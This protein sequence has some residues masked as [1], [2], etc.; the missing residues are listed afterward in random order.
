MPID[1]H[2]PQ[3]RDSYASRE[4]DASWIQQM[5]RLVDWNGKRVADIGC[6]G[7]IYS[8]ALLQLGV[9]HVYGIDFSEA[10]IQTAKELHAEESLSFLV[11]DAENTGLSNESVDIVFN[12]ALIHHLGD[13]TPFFREARRILKPDG[14]FVIQNRTRDDCLL[15]GSHTHIRGYF[16]EKFPHLT[17]VETKRRPNEQS[18]ADALSA[19]GFEPISTRQIW[20][21]RKVYPTF[22]ELEK[23][24][25]SRTGRSILHELTDEQLE[26]LVTHLREQLDEYKRE[27]IV[28]QERWTVWI[29]KKS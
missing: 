2:D 16:F 10:M 12:R 25:V 1:F 27:L 4:V 7:G 17:E 21:V 20:E 14:L 29:A 22:S 8:K 24:I 13:W 15:A 26:E 3:N 6:G 19:S 5:E 23:E 18:L 11:G 28:E 9:E